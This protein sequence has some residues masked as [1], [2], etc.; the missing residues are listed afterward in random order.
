MFYRL[1]TPGLFTFTMVME[2]I[3]QSNFNLFSEMIWDANLQDLLLNQLKFRFA[4]VKYWQNKPYK[5]S[6]EIK[7]HKE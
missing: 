2:A 5:Y 3:L 1:Y 4:H 6:S 7:W